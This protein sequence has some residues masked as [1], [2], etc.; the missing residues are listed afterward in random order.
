[1]TEN[2]NLRVVGRKIVGRPRKEDGEK[3]SV[4]IQMRV[5]EEERDFIAAEAE[6]AGKSVSEW[7][8]EKIM[9]KTTIKR[10]QGNEKPA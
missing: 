5:T 3:K 4:I 7:M 1:M 9:A 10:V 2:K 8:R 6:K